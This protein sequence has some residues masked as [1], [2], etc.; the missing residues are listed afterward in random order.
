MDYYFRFYTSQTILEKQNRCV[1]LAFP[2]KYYPGCGR[3]EKVIIKI[4]KDLNQPEEIQIHKYLSE[5][6]ESIIKV[7]DT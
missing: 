7:Y 2:Q 3:P 4:F 1:L 5:H 6:N